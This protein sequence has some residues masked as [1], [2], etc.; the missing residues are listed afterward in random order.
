MVKKSIRLMFFFRQ[1]LRHYSVVNA[2]VMSVFPW[3]I[4]LM[5]VCRG[6]AANPESENKAW[7]RG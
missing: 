3:V 7:E 1:K 6:L 5:I 2:E 4:S